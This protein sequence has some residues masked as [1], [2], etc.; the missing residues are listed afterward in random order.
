MDSSFGV[1]C[2]YPIFDPYWVH[3]C[4]QNT[5]QWPMKFMQQSRQRPLKSMH[6]FVAGDGRMR[7]QDLKPGGGDGELRI[8]LVWGSAD[9]LDLHVETPRGWACEIPLTSDRIRQVCLHMLVELV[10]A[11]VSIACGCCGKLITF[12]MVCCQ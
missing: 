9:D 2:N 5:H 12:A 6:S 1:L 4:F 8:S 7:Y 10:V 11:S 3:I